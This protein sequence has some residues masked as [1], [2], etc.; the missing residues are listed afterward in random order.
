M[1]GGEFGI[2][3][4]FLQKLSLKFHKLLKNFLTTSYN[5]FTLI[6]SVEA[7]YHNDDPVF[8]SAFCS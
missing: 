1:Y 5:I 2:S 7:T 3:S 6:I 4:K 8:Q